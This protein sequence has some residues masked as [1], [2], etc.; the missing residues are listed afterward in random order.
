MSKEAA[1]ELPSTSVVIA[2]SNSSSYTPKT[3]R[4]LDVLLVRVTELY[5]D[6]LATAAE[7]QIY[8]LLK[9]LSR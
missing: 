7:Y 9:K 5:K 8:C 3:E 2:G 1:P 4:D 6:L